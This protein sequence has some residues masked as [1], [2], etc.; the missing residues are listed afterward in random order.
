M[1][2]FKHTMAAFLAVVLIG[3]LAV[4]QAAEISTASADKIVKNNN[5]ILQVS[6]AGS[7]EDADTVN[8]EVSDEY[9]ERTVLKLAEPYDIKDYAEAENFLVYYYGAEQF[10]EMMMSMYTQN[11][12][13]ENATVR[14]DINQLFSDKLNK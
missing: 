1:H 6:D 13:A 3:S 11:W 5:D 12:I 2:N 7:N 4:T 14:E 9:Y 10:N 8:L